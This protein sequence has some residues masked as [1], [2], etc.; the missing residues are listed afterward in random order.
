MPKISIKHKTVAINSYNSFVKL[1]DFE[2]FDI[3]ALGVGDIS[4]EGKKIDVICAILDL[5]G[6]TKFC[7]QSEPQIVIPEFLSIYLSWF[8][9]NFRDAFTVE[10]NEAKNVVK[11][12]G[13]LPFY[14]K[15]LGDGLLLL[16]D[17]EHCGG[18]KGIGNI[19]VSLYN[20]HVR[21]VSDFLQSKG[22]EFVDCPLQLRCGIARGSVIEIGNG[23]D[24]VGGCINMAS[25]LQKL[26]GLPFC[27]QR[28]GMS[29]DSI[30][31]EESQQFWELKRI[32]IRGVGTDELVYVNKD[33]FDELDESSKKHFLDM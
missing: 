4:K 18:K 2:T 12:F 16:W 30:F 14:I 5:E 24:Y 9:K 11:I 23:N 28:R 21:Y 20:L 10:K 27:F 25:R 33:E 8:M 6:F 32:Q 13:A 17:L 22:K 31:D 3:P 1:N 7:N 26:Y 15:F 29:I 19:I